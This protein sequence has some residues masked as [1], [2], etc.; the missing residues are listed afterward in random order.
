MHIGLSRQDTRRSD[1]ASEPG[2]KLVERASAVETE[3]ELV[4]IRLKLGTTAMAGTQDEGL[5]IAD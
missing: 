3:A 1:S 4:E 2:K 5:E